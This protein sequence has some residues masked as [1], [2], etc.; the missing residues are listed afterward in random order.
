M[1]KQW[2]PMLWNSIEKDTRVPFTLF[3]EEW[4]RA[5]RSICEPEMKLWDSASNWEGT[6]ASTKCWR[7]DSIS[8]HAS[9]LEKFAVYN[10]T[11]HHDPVGG[12]VNKHHRMIRWPVHP[13]DAF[14]PPHVLHFPLSIGGAFQV[15]I[16]S[17]F[18]QD[19]IALNTSRFITSQNLSYGNWHV[20]FEMK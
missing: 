12:R 16:L 1:I 3:I 19:C 15:Y 2:I 10:S 11:P 17:N 8:S 7:S 4:Q 6:I 13:E 14:R 9:E 18:L 20:L 5:R